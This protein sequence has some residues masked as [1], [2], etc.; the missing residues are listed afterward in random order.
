MEPT[1]IPILA[2]PSHRPERPQVAFHLDDPELLWGLRTLRAPITTRDNFWS[3]VYDL[4][5]E[6]SAAGIRFP[7]TGPVSDEV[8]CPTWNPE[9]PSQMRCYPCALRAWWLGGDPLSIR[10]FHGRPDRT[11]RI[12]WVSCRTGCIANGWW[13]CDTDTPRWR[14]IFLQQ[15]HLLSALLDSFGR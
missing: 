5:A 13:R 7:P 2:A 3:N 4:W 12:E 15:L 14:T 9:G 11:M 1:E 10:I 8:C 6:V